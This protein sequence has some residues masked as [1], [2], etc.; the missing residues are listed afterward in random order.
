MTLR[1]P[2][3]AARIAAETA[4]FAP[5]RER[6]PMPQ[7]R[8]RHGDLTTRER[9]ACSAQAVELDAAAIEIAD[10]S[11]RLPSHWQSL[12]LSALRAWKAENDKANRAQQADRPGTG[13]G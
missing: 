10:L 4:F 6:A 1:K 3:S 13:D 11:T 12:V 7:G 8:T 9:T 2:P 5:T